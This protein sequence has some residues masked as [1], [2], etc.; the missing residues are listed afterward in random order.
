MTNEEWH[1]VRRSGDRRTSQQTSTLHDVGSELRLPS[2]VGHRTSLRTGCISPNEQLFSVSTVA[3]EKR[4][5]D[6]FFLDVVEDNGKINLLMACRASRAHI[7]RFGTVGAAR[8]LSG[9]F[10]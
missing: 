6:P 5:P 1:C 2:R 3:C 8:P 7:V 10:G 9:D 4:V